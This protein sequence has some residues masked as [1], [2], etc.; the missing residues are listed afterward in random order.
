[1]EEL[2]LSNHAKVRHDVNGFI[3]NV[4][5]VLDLLV[6]STNINEEQREYCTVLRKQADNVY[7][8]V[9]ENCNGI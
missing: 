3:H 1:M 2:T 7:G 4:M 8:C 5:V 6:A 9:K